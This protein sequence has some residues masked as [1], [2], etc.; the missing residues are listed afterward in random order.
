MSR[1]EKAIEK[2]I[3]TRKIEPASEP[4]LE[5]VR[6]NHSVDKLLQVEPL[7]APSPLLLVN[8]AEGRYIVEEYKKLKSQIVQMTDGEK[9]LN[10][11]M[12]TSTISGEGKT[13]TVLNLAISLA[14]EIDH[15]VLVVDADLRQPSVHDYLGIKPQAGLVQCL[16]E[17]VPLEDVLVKTGIGKLVVL[18]AGSSVSNPVELLSSKRMKEMVLELKKRYPDRYVLFDT[19]PVLSFAESYSLASVMDGVVFVTREGCAK[20]HQVQMA[21]ENLKKNSNILGVVY[22][23]SHFVSKKDSDYYSYY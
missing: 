6:D 19:T 2:A 14:Q 10:T 17:N 18:P 8:Q 5:A 23:D 20:S 4:R 21:L 9:F 11:L 12:F 3:K 7:K 15:T 13:L 22:N 1:L 16:K